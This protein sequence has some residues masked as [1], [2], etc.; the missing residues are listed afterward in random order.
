[1][2]TITNNAFTA[3]EAERSAQTF[4]QSAIMELDVLIEQLTASRQ[5]MID[6]KSFGMGD[7]PELRL[8]QVIE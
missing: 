4:R 5:A 2:N 3:E 8:K 7:C 1:M 6:G